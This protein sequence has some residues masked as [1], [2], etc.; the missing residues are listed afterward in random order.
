MQDSRIDNA[1]ADIS[2]GQKAVLA[3]G[4]SFTAACA[5]LRELYG[6]L[7][8]ADRE[9]VRVKL[10]VSYL[11]AGVRNADLV[12]E[13]GTNASAGLALIKEAS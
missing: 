7:P 6:E 11:A 3:A 1:I 13:F 12:A 4:V 8:A 9:A 2:A 10:A 5:T